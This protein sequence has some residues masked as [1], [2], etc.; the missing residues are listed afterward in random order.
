MKITSI[1]PGAY[2]APDEIRSGELLLYPATVDPIVIRVGEYVR[3]STGIVLSEIAGIAG[4]VD[5]YR[6]AMDEGIFIVPAM[7]YDNVPL[8][9]VAYS[10]DGM[11]KTVNGNTPIARL[12]LLSMP[13]FTKGGDDKVMNRNAKKKVAKKKS[14]K[15]K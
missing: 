1:H 4:F 9:V 11:R 2:R 7:A 14:R 12:T 13:L 10:S 8:E 6:L 5:G 15:K 3:I